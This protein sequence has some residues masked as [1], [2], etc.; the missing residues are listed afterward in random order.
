M[1]CGDGEKEIN[2][3]SLFDE[4]SLVPLGAVGERYWNT[5]SAMGAPTV[6]EIRYMHVIFAQ[7]GFPYSEVPFGQPFQR[8]NGSAVLGLT[9]GYLHNPV[10]KRLELQGLPYGSIPRLLMLYICNEAK[11]A[12]T[13]RI[14]MNRSMTS[15]L[16]HDLLVSPSGGVRGGL[17]M[18]KKQMN[19][20]A[21]TPITIG[22]NYLTE[23]GRA[24]GATFKPTPAIVEYKVW[25][26][27]SLI[28]KPMW[29]TEVTLSES[30]FDGV[31]HHS[32][33]LDDR[34][35]QALRKSPLQLD[36]YFN[37]AQRLPRMRGNEVQ[38][39]S[40]RVL[41]EQVGQEYAEVKMFKFRYLE[42][43]AKVKRV[44]PDANITYDAD[45]IELRR[46]KAP[47]PS[48]LLLLSGK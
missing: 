3:V 24:G 33:P 18:F 6:D 30:F 37:L 28:D 25:D 31:I 46:S 45:G 21:A 32:V 47:I 41:R 43:L 17:T 11:R 39:I 7:T 27:D 9:P 36:T 29:H 5:V 20:V 1:E 14:D 22:L 19:R 13:K 15:F 44:Y 34:A 8:R 4:P 40:W 16:R 10:T 38:R 12:K 35:I 42:A 48:N 26:D 2:L 23:K